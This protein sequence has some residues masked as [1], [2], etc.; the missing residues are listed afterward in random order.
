M[1]KEF[2]LEIADT[3]SELINELAGLDQ[4]DEAMK[5]A[6]LTHLAKLDLTGPVEFKIGSYDIDQLQDLLGN[7][8]Q[9]VGLVRV[10]P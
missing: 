5:A 3:P 2:K 8:G 6:A 1:T 10:R 7:G 4:F 9:L